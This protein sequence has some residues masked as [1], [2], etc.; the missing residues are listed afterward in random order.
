MSCKNIKVYHSETQVFHSSK[1]GAVKKQLNLRDKEIEK[2]KK[3]ILSTNPGA[4]TNPFVGMKDE[5]GYLL[6]NHI[7]PNVDFLSFQ[8]HSRRLLERIPGRTIRTRTDVD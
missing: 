8:P 6:I 3:T 7:D 5:S 2:L 1:L 4:S